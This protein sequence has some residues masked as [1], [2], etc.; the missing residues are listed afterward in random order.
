[1][2]NYS[3]D[4]GTW[5]Y[6]AG[7]NGAA[8]TI[9]AGLPTELIV[10]PVAP[11]NVAFSYSNDI[12]VVAWKASPG[13]KGYKVFFDNKL[14][15]TL[16]EVTSYT[17]NTATWVKGKQYSIQIVAFNEAG[18]S[19]KSN[20]VRGSVPKQSIL[21]VGNQVFINGKALP[22]SVKPISIKGRTYLPFKAIFEP[23]GVKA[24]W[25]NKTKVLNASKTNFKLTLTINNSSAKL[26]G[27]DVKLDAAPVIMNGTTYV[28]LRFVGESLGVPVQYRAK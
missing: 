11:T 4:V 6:T 24:L 22:A 20:L 15:E 1:M 16:G 23:F 25:N 21:V 7:I 2:N 5:T 10:K 3:F 12:A 18:E 9:V 27:K 26:N 14:L 13:A 19:V 28:P 8:G 17:F